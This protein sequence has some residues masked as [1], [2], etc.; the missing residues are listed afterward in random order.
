MPLILRRTSAGDRVFRA[1]APFLALVAFAMCGGQKSSASQSPTPTS[2][3][4]TPTP[5]GPWQLA[6]SDEF[7]GPDGSRPDE[8]L[9]TYDLGGNGWGNQE[10]ET[11]TN[12][13]ENAS[14]Q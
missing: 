14:V 6:W 7:N 12:R 4:P 9:W 8:S 5:S 3:T 2:P 1:V 11:Y 13:A 10:L